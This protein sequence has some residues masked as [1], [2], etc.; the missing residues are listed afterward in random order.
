M[1][2]H[3]LFYF[4]IAVDLHAAFPVFKSSS[5]YSFKNI[6]HLRINVFLESK[7][8]LNTFKTIS[9]IKLIRSYVLLRRQ[10]LAS[11]KTS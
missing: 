6:D 3:K 9:G 7:V 11:V 2:I 5:F 8:I 1:K 10:L 4:I